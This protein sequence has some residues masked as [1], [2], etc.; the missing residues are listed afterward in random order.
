MRR[1]PK[2]G[3]EGSEAVRIAEIKPCSALRIK[4]VVYCRAPPGGAEAGSARYPSCYT[5]RVAF[6]NRWI[7]AADDGGI[8]FRWKDYREYGLARSTGSQPL[9]VI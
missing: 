8:A 6:S 7:V 5:H 1:C 4:W 2:E 3:H 9:W